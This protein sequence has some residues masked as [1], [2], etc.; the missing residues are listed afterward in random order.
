MQYLETY[1]GKQLLQNNFF[2]F[3][4]AQLTTKFICVSVTGVHMHRGNVRREIGC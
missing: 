1:D 4:A 2:Y 3:Q